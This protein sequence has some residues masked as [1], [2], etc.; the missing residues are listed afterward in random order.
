MK[1]RE[2]SRLP[3]IFYRTYKSVKYSQSEMMV[4]QHTFYSDC[5]KFSTFKKILCFEFLEYFWVAV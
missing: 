1:E 4:H 5:F 2:A 3:L